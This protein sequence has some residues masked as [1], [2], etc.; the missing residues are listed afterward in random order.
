[1]QTEDNYTFFDEDEEEDGYDLDETFPEKDQ[2]FRKHY[3]EDDDEYEE[4][5]YD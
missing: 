2:E 3:L 1:V 4:E 5:F